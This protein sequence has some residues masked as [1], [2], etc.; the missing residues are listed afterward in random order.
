MGRGT[1]GKNKIRVEYQCGKHRGQRAFIIASGP[2]IAGMDLDWLRGEVTICVNE[3]YK[4]IPFDP[5]YI[6]IGDK[7]LWPLVKG[8][9]AKKSS[10]IVCSSGLDGKVG[11]EYH[12]ENM[13]C[14]F[15]LIKTK[16]VVQHGFSWDLDV[17][18]HK[19]F[20]VITETAIPFCCW[21]GFSEV[22]LI[23]CDCTNNG[24]FYKESSRGVEHQVVSDSAMDAYAFIAKE[25]LPTKIYNAGVGGNLECFPRKDFAT[26]KRKDQKLLVVG[27]YT[28]DKNYEKLANNMKDSVER[29]GVPCEIQERGSWAKPNMPKPLPWV[30][31]CSQ[32]SFFIRE[33]REKYPDRNLL[34]L[35]ADAEMVRRPALFLDGVPDFDFAA[36]FL[37]NR[38]VKNQLSSN[39][40]YFST[41]PTATAL[42]D[43]WVRLQEERNAILLGGGYPKPYAAAWDQKTLQDVMATI[44]KLRWA[45][46]P[47][48]YGKLSLTP[49][50]EELMPGIDPNDVVIMQYQASR[51]NKHEV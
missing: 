19:S 34:Y 44:P 39:T 37:F 15:P 5:T 25:Q 32:C 33:M 38:Y 45:Q 2:S 35:D 30:L 16:T 28:P 13:V 29:F 40:L 14:Q 51:Q 24:Y 47:Y 21:A 41:A 6:C 11:T 18:V 8:T 42:L 1:R 46:L 7:A 20:N 4:A 9:Y 49:K 17:G 50:G 48:I 12:G 36:P 3:S 26:L 22:Y 31:N 27:Y 43:A 10:G 23:G